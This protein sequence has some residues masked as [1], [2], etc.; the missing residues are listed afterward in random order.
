MSALLRFSIIFS[1]HLNLEI[2]IKSNL[3][4]DHL[5]FQYSICSH[6]RQTE[7]GFENLNK[8]TPRFP[9]KKPESYKK[10]IDN[11]NHFIF[12]IFFIYSITIHY[13]I[14]TLQLHFSITLYTLYLKYKIMKFLKILTYYWNTNMLL[15]YLYRNKSE[16]KAEAVDECTQE[17]GLLCAELSK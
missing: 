15:S 14:K 5:A 17:D 9:F 4:L 16:D 1:H 3:F 12:F 8:S 2:S 6:T 10:N 11:N 7:K 13:S